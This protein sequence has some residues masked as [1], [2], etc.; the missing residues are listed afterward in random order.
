MIVTIRDGRPR[1]NVQGR[2]CQRLTD[3]CKIG[4]QRIRITPHLCPG[5]RLRSESV[6]CLNHT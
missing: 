1:L 5:K 4:S 6:S 2:I 3:D